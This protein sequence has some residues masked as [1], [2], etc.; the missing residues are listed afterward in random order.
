MSPLVPPRHEPPGMR[1]TSPVSIPKDV[2]SDS[3]DARGSESAQRLDSLPSIH[4]SSSTTRDGRDAQPVSCAGREGAGEVEAAYIG[5]SN[6]DAPWWLREIGS[7]VRRTR[8]DGGVSSSLS[9]RPMLRRP[10]EGPGSA[11]ST[12][13]AGRTWWW[14]WWGPHAGAVEVGVVVEDVLVAR[15]AGGDNCEREMLVTTKRKGRGKGKEWERPDIGKTGRKEGKLRR[16]THAAG[17]GDERKGKPKSTT[18]LTEQGRREVRDDGEG[19]K[20]SEWMGGWRGEGREDGCHGGRVGDEED[21]ERRGRDAVVTQRRRRRH[22]RRG[23]VEG[24][25]GR[26]VERERAAEGMVRDEGKARRD[27]GGC[28]EGRTRRQRIEG[29]ERQCMQWKG[30]ERGPRIGD[31]KKNRRSSSNGGAKGRK[32]CVDVGAGFSRGEKEARAAG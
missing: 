3:K 8:C 2:F 31:V 19:G 25:K 6:S 10:A 16:H 5:K 22:G 23:G 28:E 7:R 4:P 13:D 27:K 24:R 17:D 26:R 12:R 30:R 15:D 32:E 20:R 18:Q 21:A 9:R 1:S 14:W 29:D 11:D